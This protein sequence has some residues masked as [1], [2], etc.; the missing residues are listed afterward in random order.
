MRV[1]ASTSACL[2][3]ERRSAGRNHHVPFG[4]Q[5]RE[6]VDVA[7]VDGFDVAAIELGDRRFVGGAWM[8]ACALARSAER[9]YEHAHEQRRDER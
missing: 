4:R 5:A 7:V 9:S 2:P 1:M 3:V 6:R 8:R